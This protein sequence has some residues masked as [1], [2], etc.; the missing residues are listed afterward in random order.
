MLKSKCRGLALALA[1]GLGLTPQ[2]SWALGLGEI[3][4]S[5]ALNE[6]FAARIELLETGGLQASE[7]LVSMASKEDFDR[8]G[9][10]R[11]FY[12][13]D[14]RFDVD[15]SDGTPAVVLRSR[16]PI[17]EPYLNFIIE[18]LWPQGRLLKEYTVLLDPP[19]FSTTQA[20][21]VTP[22]AQPAATPAPSPSV[23]STPQ[24][25]TPTR[26]TLPRSPQAPAAR[27]Q[28]VQ[29]D[30][31]VM[32]TVDDTLWKIAS[33]TLGG[34]TTVHQQM[35]AIQR[36]N[37]QAF[38]RDNINLLKAGYALALPGEGDAQSIS[39]A[40]ARAAVAQQTQQWL[41]P[42]EAVAQRTERTT[43]ETPG[44]A[45]IDATASADAPAPQQ[46]NETTGQVR[47]VANSGNTV[48]GSDAAADANPALVEQNETLTR[49]VDELTYQLDR[50]KELAANQIQLKDRQLDVKNAELAQ[51][52]D[53][54]GRLEEQLDQL[55]QNQNQNAASAATP[56][57]PVAWW[58]SPLFLGGL[59]G[60]LVLGLAAMLLMMRRQRDAFEEELAAQAL[61]NDTYEPEPAI[62]D[63]VPAE[64]TEGDTVLAFDD[65][66]EAEPDFDELDNLIAEEEDDGAT[67]IAP[68]VAAADTVEDTFEPEAQA[69]ED[70]EEAG[71]VIGEADIYVAYGR[72]GQAVS[73]LETALIS[74]PDRHDVRLKLAE[75]CVEAGDG[76]NFATHA[77]YLV[78]NCEDGDVLL[79]VREL[80]ARM[81]EQAE[82]AGASTPAEAVPADDAE[83]AGEDEALTLDDLDDELA[84]E[85]DSAEEAVATAD[86]GDE[87]SLGD[88]ETGLDALAPEDA[89][90]AQEDGEANAGN[91]DEFEL[92][93]DDDAL[94]VDDD[95]AGSLG[96]HLGIDFDPDAGDTEAAGEVEPE[97]AAPEMLAMALE[98][99]LEDDGAHEPADAAES[100]DAVAPAAEATAE[101]DEFDLEFDLD[102]DE[103]ADLEGSGAETAAVEALDETPGEPAA[104][105]EVHQ[106]DTTV[107]SNPEPAGAEGATG[108]GNASFDDEDFDFGETGDA[109]INATK[110]DLAEAYIDM[111]DGDGASDILK[112]VAEEGD[113]DQQARARELLDRLAS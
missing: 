37:P 91:L 108:D 67:R 2:V 96:G 63:E 95:Q 22:P 59:I 53:R 5:S 89:A 51:L 70:S 29:Q 85:D 61:V 83:D 47:I 74:D 35:L 43:V 99:T 78:D 49:Q 69:G 104:M 30:G 46:V 111:G 40:E 8:V 17:S 88:L 41:N 38:M 6:K 25:R 26:V 31:T 90:A 86:S 21:A 42:G 13:T 7:V 23:A 20:P 58:Q 112:E 34:S 87:L 1:L 109:D 84:L 16:T 27:P 12:L 57:A 107:N 98:D 73:L 76:A 45:Q 3:E 14:I 48:Q 24:P 50:E 55:A 11:F 113:P 101:S 80:E 36:L 52:Q 72:Y 39:D 10:E 60:V 82:L 33:R 28:A 54:L 4:V 94:A 77:G 71:D 32:S 15:M 105:A 100:L 92:E 62:A 75:V 9:V 79:A 68:V 93:F 18:V 102:D 81:E 44:R 65:E 56:P 110:L 106:L 19:T 97:A 64:D 103:F 66:V